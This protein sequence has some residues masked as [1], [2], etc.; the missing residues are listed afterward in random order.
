[1]AFLENP[2]GWYWGLGTE[3]QVAILALIAAFFIGYFQVRIGQ[4]Q[5]SINASIQEVGLRPI[6]LR[7][8]TDFT[9]EQ[10]FNGFNNGDVFQFVVQ[11][12]IARNV[13]G[14]IV[15]NNRKYRLLFDIA[16]KLPENR[17]EWGPQF[18]HAMGWVKPDEILCSIYEVGSFVE[19]DH[20][21]EVYLSYEDIAGNKYCT[22]EDLAYVQSSRKI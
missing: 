21:N 16:R 12:N 13:Q 2:I 1:M 22:V 8:G 14:H 18:M 7:G 10:I 5:N 4:R 3:S 17:I 6:I 15:L 9:W 19:V 20:P 11:R